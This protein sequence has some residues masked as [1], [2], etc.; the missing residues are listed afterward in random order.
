[1]TQPVWSSL[2]DEGPSARSVSVF[3]TSRLSCCQPGRPAGTPRGSRREAGWS[4]EW[5]SDIIPE[6]K[7]ECREDDASL[8]RARLSGNMKTWGCCVV[9]KCIDLFIYRMS[10]YIFYF[11]FKFV[12]SHLCHPSSVFIYLRNHSRILKQNSGGFCSSSTVKSY[13]WLI[14]FLNKHCWVRAGQL[15][16]ELH[17]LIL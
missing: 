6:V 13:D 3:R 5:V 1:M 12:L 10:I 8:I 2:P 17:L 11:I 16:H 14:L 7:N 9:F 15:S 4:Q